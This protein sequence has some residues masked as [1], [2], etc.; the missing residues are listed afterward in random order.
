VKDIPISVVENF[1]KVYLNSNEKCIHVFSLV[2][3][4]AK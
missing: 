1:V 4:K 3:N 2:G